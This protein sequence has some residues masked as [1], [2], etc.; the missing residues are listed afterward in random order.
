MV[1]YKGHFLSAYGMAFIVG[2]IG[3]GL[4]ATDRLKAACACGAGE[5]EKRLRREDW[6][7]KKEASIL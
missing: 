6:H 7:I 4:P 1:L 2:R 5:W 3:Q